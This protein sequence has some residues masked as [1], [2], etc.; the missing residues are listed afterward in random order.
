MHIVEIKKLI[1]Y[2]ENMAAQT[3]TCQKCNKQFLVIDQEQAFLREKNLPLPPNCPSCR[4]MRRLMLRGERRLYKT[5]C[6]KCSKEII[7]SYDPS[8]VTNQI[9]CKADY[10]Q[11]FLDHNNLVHEPLPEI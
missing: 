5:K 9:L 8:K 2:S 1:L 4:Q 7:V 11:Y 6:H 10:D 3:L